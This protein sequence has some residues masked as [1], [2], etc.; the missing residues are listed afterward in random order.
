MAQDRGAFKTIPTRWRRVPPLA[1][2]GSAVAAG[3]HR[4]KNAFFGTAAAIRAFDFTNA[5]ESIAVFS[6][7]PDSQS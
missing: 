4:P 5:C 3:P 7:Q 6:I 2:V 1:I